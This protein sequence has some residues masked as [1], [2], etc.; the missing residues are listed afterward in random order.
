MIK[1]YLKDLKICK[2]L[3]GSNKILKTRIKYLHLINY[4]CK[5]LIRDLRNHLEIYL[6]NRIIQ[7]VI[8]FLI[9]YRENY[10]AIIK[11]IRKIYLVN[12]DL[13]ELKYKMIKISNYLEIL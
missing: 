13:K 10:K 3:A 7:T 9:E 6:R 8:S 5:L 4:L 1:I 11:F 12:K 2:M